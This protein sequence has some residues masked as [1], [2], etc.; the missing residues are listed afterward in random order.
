MGF[1]GGTYLPP[2]SPML[3]STSAPPPGFSSSM[4]SGQRPSP[5]QLHP[6][7]YW[8]EYWH[9]YRSGI[10]YPQ[11]VKGSKDAMIP[12][13]N[14][15]P[16]G[17]SEAKPPYSPEEYYQDWLRYQKSQSHGMTNVD[18]VQVQQ[19]T[20]GSANDLTAKTQTGLAKSPS[21]APSG[22]ANAHGRTEG[23]ETQAKGGPPAK[24]APQKHS[25]ADT[26]HVNIVRR[27]SKSAF[28]PLEHQAP[29]ARA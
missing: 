10:F 23:E 19:Q 1:P 11:P 9:N 8:N 13:S 18:Q 17:Y 5:Y 29:S 15:P 25:D 2:D 21:K 22:V 24:S 20:A 6:F 4:R 26:A 14:G 12:I 16:S 27:S 3:A 28:S 7:H